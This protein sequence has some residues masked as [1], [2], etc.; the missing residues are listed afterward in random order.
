MFFLTNFLT[1]TIV[2]CNAPSRNC[3]LPTKEEWMEGSC[4]SCFHACNA[5]RVAM[6]VPVRRMLCPRRLNQL[7]LE[8][9][10][11]LLGKQLHLLEFIVPDLLLVGTVV[12]AVYQLVVLGIAVRGW[13]HLLATHVH[14]DGWIVGALHEV[15][16][17]AGKD[18]RGGHENAKAD[19]DLAHRGGVRLAHALLPVGEVVA[20]AQVGVG[21]AE[22]EFVV[23]DVRL[24][25]DGHL[26]VEGSPVRVVGAA[27]VRRVVSPVEMRAEAEL[28]SATAVRSV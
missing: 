20:R 1:F 8:V 23:G 15:E 5:M 17:H 19:D 10:H 7:L 24:E 11:I 22:V 21:S 13:Y 25:A 2:A 14:G 6:L 3:S 9:Q 27:A 12:A 4:A 16:C 26:G 28:A 18:D